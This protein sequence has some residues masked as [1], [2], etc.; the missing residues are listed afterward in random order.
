M[1]DK[2]Y[3]KNVSIEGAG[4]VEGVFHYYDATIQTNSLNERYFFRADNTTLRSIAEK[5][6]QGVSILSG[7]YGK[8][9]GKS[10]S[11]RLYDKKV[12]SNFFVRSGL[13][14]VNSD[15][16]IARLDSGITSEVSTGFRLLPESKMTRDVCS[17]QMKQKYSWFMSYFECEEGHILGQMLKK[18]GKRVTALLSGPVDLFEYSLVRE[19]ADPG[20]RII[21]KI[22]ENLKNGIFDE[23]SL[24]SFA[25]CQNIKFD[26][27]KT[28][29]YTHLT[30][31]TK[32]IV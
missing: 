22:S 6:A 7:H 29:S 28:V 3:I 15:D 2:L 16:E 8:A 18:G 25:E 14:D 17:E 10:T 24:L 4:A 11:G 32:R 26:S 21:K 5:A 27:F 1:S 9:L 20:N 19:G 30:L 23:E 13:K 12:M 31:P